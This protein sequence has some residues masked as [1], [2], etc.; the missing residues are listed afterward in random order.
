M[1]T[2]IQLSTLVF[3]AAFIWGLLLIL[4]GTPLSINLFEPF[5]NVIGILV[6][7][8]TFFD[9]WAWHWKIFY[10][11]LVS[12]PYIEGTWKGKINS[13][14]VNPNTKQ[15][16]ETIDAYLVVR[17]KF[18][19]AYAKLITKE[20]SSELLAGEIIKN[21]YET[22]QFVSVY[23]NIPKMLIRKRSPIHYGSMILSI[24]G[25]PPNSLEG[26]YWTDR[27]TQGEITFSGFNRKKF[28]DYLSAST[29]YYTKRS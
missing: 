17:Q 9:K 22:W 3:V 25:H 18:S 16:I 29:A 26:Q 12:T 1:I 5:Y 11:W 6:L 7:V 14:W 27:N 10:P 24:K 13:N 21:T 23:R 2:D 15:K 4:K 19:K 8:L 28:D 20:S